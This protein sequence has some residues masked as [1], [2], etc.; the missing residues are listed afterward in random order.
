VTSL[1]RGLLRGAGAGSVGTTALN[2][3]TSL[4]MAVRG[5]PASDAP[6]EVVRRAADRAR[7]PLSRRRRVRDHRAEGLGAVAGIGTGVGLGAVAGVLRAAGVRLPTAAG[8]PLLGAAAML[9]SDVPLVRLGVSDPRRWSAVDW[10]SD[11]VPHLVYG[12][13]THAVLVA[14]S[15]TE[16]QHPPPGP[17]GAAAPVPSAGSV[18]AP[19]PPAPS[20][21]DRSA[22]APSALTLLRALALGAASGARSSA[23]LAAVAWTADGGDAGPVGRRLGSGGGRT[24]TALMAAGEAAAD[25]TPAVPSR[26][27][28]PALAAR[29]ASGATSAGVV[30]RRAGEE[31]GLPA[32]AAVLAAVG[33]ALA[34]SRLR[35]RAADRFGSDLPGALVEDAMAA[36]LGWF[37]A[38]RTASGLP[39]P[40]PVRP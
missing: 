39:S 5:R 25:K 14:S 35:G 38:R 3:L 17:D 29:M 24:L 33:S 36:V 12:V 15:R 4:D 30:A 18:P 23:G 1:L 9:A 37:G 10:A 8:G 7:I 27:A 6:A 21:P 22:S 13:T 19:S 40:E 32:L 20:P 16:Q 11:V 2:A 26:T 34:G 28:P 31:P